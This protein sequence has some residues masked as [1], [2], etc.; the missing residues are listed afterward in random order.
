[1]AARRRQVRIATSSRAELVRLAAV[2]AH[3]VEDLLAG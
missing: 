2:F 1:M 3:L